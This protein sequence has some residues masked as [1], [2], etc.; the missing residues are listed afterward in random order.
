MAYNIVSSELQKTNLDSYWLII[1]HFPLNHFIFEAKTIWSLKSLLTPFSFSMFNSTKRILMTTAAASK[2]EVTVSMIVTM[3]VSVIMS[4]AVSML[5]AMTV[6]ML[7]T[8]VMSMLMS[9]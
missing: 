9:M 7:M 3:I 2:E 8:M 1:Q 4:M 6:T 5:M